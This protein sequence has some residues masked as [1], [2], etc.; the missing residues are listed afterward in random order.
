KIKFYRRV[1]SRFDK[2][3]INFMGFLHFVSALI[4]LR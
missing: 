2:K 1:F 4:W 3:A